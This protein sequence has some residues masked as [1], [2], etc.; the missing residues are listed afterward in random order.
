MHFPTVTDL[1]LPSCRAPRKPRGKLQR[2]ILSSSPDRIP[3]QARD[4]RSGQNSSVLPRDDNGESCHSERTR[5]ILSAA[6]DRISRSARDDRKG[7]T[8]IDPRL[9][10]DDKKFQGFTLIELL[11]VIAIIAILAV[12]VI[13]TL[14]PGEIMKEA[15]DS[16]RLS[17]LSTFQS[18]MNVYTADSAVGGGSA[19]LGTPGTIY[20]SI[21]DPSATSSAGTNCSAL[22]FPSTGYHCA[23]PS[24]YR[25]TN[26]TGW[27]PVNFSS[28]SSNPLGSLPVDP[29]NTSSSNDYYEYT[30]NG[31]QW[32][33]SAVPAS[34]KYASQAPSFTIG[35]DPSLLGG[36]AWVSVPG[37]SQFGTQNFL[38][39]KYDASCVNLATGQPLTGPLDGNGYQDNKS[40]ATNCTAANGL[41]PAAVPGAVQIVDVSETSAKSYC[42][43]IGAHLLTNDEYMTIVTNAANQGSNW[44][45]GSVGSGGMYL[46][47]ANN[48]S[49][50]PADPSDANGYSNGT[51]GTMTNQTVTN[52][53]DE[54]RTYTLS[55]GSIIWDMSGNL[56]QEVQRSNMNQGDN[57]NTITPPTC[58]NGTAGWEWCQYN[59]TAPY[60]TAYNDPSFSAATVAP[61]NT[62]W[63]SA[64]GMG[65]LY[66]YGSGANQG[67]NAFIRGG[68]WAYGAGDGPFALYLSW[69]TSN[70]GNVVGFRCAR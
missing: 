11:V 68:S 51:G 30:A 27:I 15:Q 44:T 48:A 9:R 3:R 16:N 39:M 37:N 47:N 13:L 58:S 60:V 56:W 55:N 17:D 61:P 2:S 23:G 6:S 4:D 65:Q 19:N 57:T 66:T 42:Q 52:T 26:G 53:G 14:N 8:L 41:A 22:G 46:G 28:L 69:D 33:M 34:T 18:A 12:V 7:F 50:Y 59:S 70:T 43:A 29:T 25:N 5:G 67:T 24:Y 1:F 40:S 20:V 49:E 45:G 10:G 35:S 63:T 21:P 38:V 32:A 54:R 64:Q 62:S 31:T 36:T